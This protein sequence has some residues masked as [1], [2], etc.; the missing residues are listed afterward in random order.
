MSEPFRHLR[1]IGARSE[2]IHTNFAQLVFDWVD[3][4]TRGKQTDHSNKS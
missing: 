1:V 3:L 2:V 4:E